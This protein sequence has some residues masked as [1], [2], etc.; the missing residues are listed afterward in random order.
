MSKR[1]QQKKDEEEAR[2]LAAKREKEARKRLKREEQI[3]QEKEE[4]VALPTTGIDISEPGECPLIA[5]AVAADMMFLL[6]QLVVG[7]GL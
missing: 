2:R 7:L 5:V 1:E 3:L 4:Q 6:V